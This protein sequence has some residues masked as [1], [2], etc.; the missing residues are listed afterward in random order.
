MDSLFQTIP[1]NTQPLRKYEPL[2]R[3]DAS[4]NPRP[5]KLVSESPI[6]DSP[7]KKVD[8]PKEEPKATTNS[9]LSSA[10]TK[11]Q[12]DLKRKVIDPPAAGIEPKKKQQ[13]QAS[14]MNFFAKKT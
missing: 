2:I 13:K 14:I 5:K 6:F 10:T 9:S 4:G 7:P 11:P 3:F 12:E 1:V 8:K